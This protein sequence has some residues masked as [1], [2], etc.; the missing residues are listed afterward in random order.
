MATVAIKSLLLTSV[1]G[2]T[3]QHLD[4]ADFDS[5]KRRWLG[6]AKRATDSDACI[7]HADE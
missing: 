5:E 7:F 3:C 6:N 4:D 2:L 1:M